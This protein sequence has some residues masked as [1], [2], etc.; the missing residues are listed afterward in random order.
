[1]NETITEKERILASQL[2]MCAEE[3]TEIKKKLEER[4]WYI[5]FKWIADKF[6]IEISKD[7]RL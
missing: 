1:M 7:L 3:I 4:G 5:Q 2:R 6:M